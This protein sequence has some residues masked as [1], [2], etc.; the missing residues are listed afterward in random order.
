MN[1]RNYNR[2]GVKNT[3]K[4]AQKASCLYWTVTDSG[5]YSCLSGGKFAGKKISSAS[6][7]M[8]HYKDQLTHKLCLCRKKMHP[9]STMGKQ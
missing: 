4:C 2:L 8:Q 6:S 9:Y 7:M 3:C 5:G 1:S